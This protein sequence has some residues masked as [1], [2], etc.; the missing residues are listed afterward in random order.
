MHELEKLLELRNILFE[1]HS[2]KM[3]MDHKLVEEL[4]YRVIGSLVTER[5]L[6]WHNLVAWSLVNRVVRDSFLYPCDAV[7]S[8]VNNFC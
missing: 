7:S 1:F 6:D 2:V 3:L 8:K 5:R 4:D